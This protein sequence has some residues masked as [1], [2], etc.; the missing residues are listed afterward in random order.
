MEEAKFEADNLLLGNVKMTI[1]SAGI[2]MTWS[3][4]NIALQLLQKA[5]DD[6]EKRLVE[7]A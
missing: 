7:E 6:A 2:S 5:I 3:N 4:A 1:G